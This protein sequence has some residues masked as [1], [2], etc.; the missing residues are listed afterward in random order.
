LYVT[1]SFPAHKAVVIEVDPKDEA[2]ARQF[3]A[4]VNA[5]AAN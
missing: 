1:I 4:T 5:A 3:V 2:K